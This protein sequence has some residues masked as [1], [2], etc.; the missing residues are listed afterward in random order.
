MV[1]RRDAA[2]AV[3]APASG[4]LGSI[5]AFSTDAAGSCGQGLGRCKRSGSGAGASRS[6][7]R[8]NRTIAAGPFVLRSKKGGP[9]QAPLDVPLPALPWRFSSCLGGPSV[10]EARL[11][12]I[13][14][15]LGPSQGTEQKVEGLVSDRFDGAFLASGEKLPR[16]GPV[17]PVDEATARVFKRGWVAFGNH[18]NH[19]S[20]M[21]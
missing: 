2:F 16:Q 21:K 11:S 6:P 4:R 19:V 13:I 20:T 7:W 9:P 3:G 17:S 1:R 18:S 14:D 5:I 12:S 8:P 15:P 10:G